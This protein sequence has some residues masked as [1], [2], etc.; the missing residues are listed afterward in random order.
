MW[1]AFFY[2]G[3]RDAGGGRGTTKPL[4][5]PLPLPSPDAPL[6]TPG[7]ASG[8]LSP[9]ISGQRIGAFISQNRSQSLGLLAS[10]TGRHSTPASRRYPLALA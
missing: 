9:G 1:S 10:S 8:E 4:P 2:G 6:V 5:L 7:R 3:M